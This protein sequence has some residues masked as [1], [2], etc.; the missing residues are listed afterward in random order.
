MFDILETRRLL[1]ASLDGGILTIAGTEASDNIR[2]NIVMGNLVVFH[3][4]TFSSYDP[5]D[6]AEIVINALGG[7]DI[8]FVTGEL[9]VPC[10]IDGG[11]GNDSIRGGSGFDSIFG[12]EGRDT[13]RGQRGSDTIDGGAGDDVLDGGPRGDTLIGGANSDVAY[14]SNRTEDLDISLDD[15]QNDGAAGEDDHIR[16]DVEH[17]YG[18]SGDDWI[19]GNA[20]R[21]RLRGG[22]GHDTLLPGR[23]DDTVVGGEGRDH[24]FGGHGNDTADYSIGTN[25]LLIHLDEQSLGGDGAQI[26]DGNGGFV[27]E[28]DMVSPDL[29]TILGGSGND[30]FFAYERAACFIG[31]A[32]NDT[33]VGGERNDTLDGGA[34]ADE[35]WGMAGIDTANFASR[36][37]DLII[38]LDNQA[39]DGEAGEGDNVFNDV[40]III[41]GSG[42]DFVRC[43]G[44]MNN[45][46]FGIAGND[47]LRG[48]DGDD[49]LLG[50]N[51]NDSL[52]GESN[53]D[54]LIG[55]GL[56]DLLDTL[57]GGLGSDHGTYLVGS[58]VGGIEFA[59]EW[60]I[61]EPD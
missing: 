32:G 26:P 56:D 28:N 55:P 60:V 18:G 21:N 57:F 59:T 19:V 20:H 41:C 14:Y 1:S 13:L 38:D 37:E 50:G 43:F 6:V 31:G 40:E 53:D 46:L 47:T 24:L 22:A 44:I 34:G 5:D 33:L 52:L 51:G 58:E 30:R 11:A 49:S 3:P 54:T 27:S 29:E 45:T 48:G 25:D 17:V 39:D 12:G 7:N 4:G 35:L 15:V 2:L 36:V 23:A 8:V 10:T 42:D 16:S 61:V 9:A